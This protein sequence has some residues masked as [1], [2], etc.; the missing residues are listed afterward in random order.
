MPGGGAG[1][2]LGLAACAAPASV[3]PAPDRVAV[4]GCPIPG[5]E[6][7]R[8]MLRA[9]DGRLYDITGALP[10]PALDGRAIRVTGRPSDEMSFCMQGTVTF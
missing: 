2:V 10:A 7:G 9:A 1:I 5:V 8:L 4:E 6:A 3:A